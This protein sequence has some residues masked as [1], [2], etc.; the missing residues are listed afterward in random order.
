M[1]DTSAPAPNQKVP[2]TNVNRRGFAWIWLVPIVALIIV[3]F[4][5]WNYFQKQGPGGDGGLQTRRRAGAWA[6]LG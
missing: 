6:H 3:A 5:G 2:Q 1:S 4:L